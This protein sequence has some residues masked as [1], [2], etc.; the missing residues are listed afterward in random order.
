MQK[1]YPTKV[2]QKVSPEEY[3]T[4]NILSDG[5]VI[6]KITVYKGKDKQRADYGK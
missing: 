5:R 3:K 2:V 1:Y 4:A 6:D